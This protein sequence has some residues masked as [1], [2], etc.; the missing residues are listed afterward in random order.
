MKEYER[1]NAEQRTMY[2]VLGVLEYT[3]G[4]IFVE[5]L[6]EGYPKDDA[7][8]ILK[9]LEELAMAELA[10]GRGWR[11]IKSEVSVIGDDALELYEEWREF[12]RRGLTILG[13]PEW[14]MNESLHREQNAEREQNQEDS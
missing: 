8:R 10:Y 4:A 13:F 2:D 9:E 14:V 11:A 3:P 1:M 5:R 12:V 6:P 7:F